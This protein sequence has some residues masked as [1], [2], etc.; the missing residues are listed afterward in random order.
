MKKIAIIPARGG[1]KRIPRKNIKDFCGK[2]IIQY[3]IDAALQSGIFDEVMV[4]TDDNE[5]AKISLQFGAQVPFFRSAENSND[6][7]GTFEVIEEV[8]H[9]YQEKESKIFDQLC[10]LYPTAPFVTS[11][12]IKNAMIMLNEKD[13]DS[14]FPVVEYS[15][16]VQRSL[17]IQDG[18][19][20]MRNPE[21]YQSRSQDLEKIYFDA[22][23]FYCCNIKTFLKNAKIYMENSYPIIVDNMQAQD[24]DN[25]LDWK[26]A[27]MKFVLNKRRLNN[28]QYSDN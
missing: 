28:I 1:S 2:P 19:I 4:S 26:M 3:S 15:T 22:G 14:I 11:E 13:A 18:K 21:F 9:D 12:I 7:V 27:E 16:P 6:Y 5:I 24:I 25:E 8:L 20:K 23:Q 17:K 10:I